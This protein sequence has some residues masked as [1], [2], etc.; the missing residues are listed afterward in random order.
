MVVALFNEVAD[1]KRTR[2][3]NIKLGSLKSGQFRPIE[4]AELEGFLK[5]LGLK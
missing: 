2:V 4:G 1:L 5:A 3:L